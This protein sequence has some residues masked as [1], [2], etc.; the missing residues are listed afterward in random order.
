M[1][2]ERNQHWIAAPLPSASFLDKV[3]HLGLEPISGIDIDYRRRITV[4]LKMLKIFLGRNWWNHQGNVTRSS[5][6]ERRNS[7][8]G[9]RGVTGGLSGA[10]AEQEIEASCMDKEGRSN[11]KC[12]RTTQAPEF[13]LLR[14]RTG[15]SPGFLFPATHS[16]SPNLLISSTAALK[17]K[18]SPGGLCSR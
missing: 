13:L 16:S 11:V 12:H 14:I 5:E 18:A 17:W 9:K 3:L 10:K 7:R 1:R 6:F 4:K 2:H 8:R 15:S